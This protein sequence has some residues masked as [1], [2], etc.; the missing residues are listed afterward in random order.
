M[1]SGRRR[2]FKSNLVL[3]DEIHELFCWMDSR[4]IHKLASVFIDLLRG[5]GPYY[6]HMGTT[7]GRECV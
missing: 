3:R 1:L 6:L 7:I 5:E 4:A 2:V